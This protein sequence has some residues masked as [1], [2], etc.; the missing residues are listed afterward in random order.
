MKKYVHMVKMGIP[1][2]AVKQRMIRDKYDDS[3]LEVND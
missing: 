3:K 2:G 1:L